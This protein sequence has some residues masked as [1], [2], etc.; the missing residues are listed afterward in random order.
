MS[1]HI[2]LRRNYAIAFFF[3]RKRRRLSFP[4]A[5]FPIHTH[6]HTPTHIHTACQWSGSTSK[7]HVHFSRPPKHTQ[8]ALPQVGLSPGSGRSRSLR[9]Q[10][11]WHRQIRNVVMVCKY[12]KICQELIWLHQDRALGPS[13]EPIAPL[14]HTYKVDCVR[15][16][17]KISA[18]RSSKSIVTRRACCIIS[19]WLLQAESP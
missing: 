9:E 1:V 7:R 10:A 12:G 6:T 8:R 19:P 4:F 5:S 18:T 16:H 11:R 15:L 13:C 3:Q 2:T 14:Y 17:A